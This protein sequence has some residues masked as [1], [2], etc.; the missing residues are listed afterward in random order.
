MHSRLLRTDSGRTEA[1]GRGYGRASQ[2]LYMVN[3]DLTIVIAGFRTSRVGYA[4][5]IF[6]CIA[7]F[8]L[9]YL[10]L[11]WI[12]RWQVKLIGKS[13]PLRECEWVVLENQWNEMSVLPVSARLY[14]RSL[15]TVFG[16]PDK[17]YAQYLED[18]ADPI[19]PE[20]RV[21]VYRYV[22]F[23][24]HPL[25]D[26]FVVSTGWED[27]NWKRVRAVRAGLDTDEK[28]ERENVFG[29]NI[30]DIEQKSIFQLL[31]DEVSRYPPR[32]IW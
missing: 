10:L 16:A 17:I 6:L 12:P 14:D 5:Y 3:E 21:L 31:V 9:A 30:I 20:L 18:D 15:S 19:L 13:C 28:D 27:P 11:R 23:F 4:A 29:A 32:L 7:T 25:K 1:S 24:F 2:K 8:G 22:R 26:K